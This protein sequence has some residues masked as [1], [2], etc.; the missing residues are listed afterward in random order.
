MARGAGV[1]ARSRVTHPDHATIVLDQ[2]HEVLMNTESGAAAMR[3]VAFL[4]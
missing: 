1:F 2:W 4:D 3:H